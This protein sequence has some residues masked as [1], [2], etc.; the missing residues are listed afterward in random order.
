MIIK[1]KEKDCWNC[2]GTGK[3]NYWSPCPNYGKSMRKG[4]PVC[5]A[6]RKA[7]H[8]YSQDYELTPC[9]MCKGTGK[10]METACSYVPGAVL[11]AIPVA[12]YRDYHETTWN[13]AYLGAGFAVSVLNYSDGK[14]LTDDQVIKMA[15]NHL[16]HVQ[17][18]NIGTEVEGG[19]E[20][21]DHLGIFT[22][23]L[24]FNVRKV[25]SN[26]EVKLL[27]EYCYD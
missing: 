19:I 24:G 17:Y 13:E 6:T 21:C 2:G 26:E 20:L 16:T 1:F 18:C 3:Y 27:K 22:G 4:C 14:N 8:K 5:K 23:T 7:E 11:A 15:R 9:K 12:V 10:L 25:M